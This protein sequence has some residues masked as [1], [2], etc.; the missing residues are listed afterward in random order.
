MASPGIQAL[1]SF[2][3]APP[4]Q[5]A[6]S[7]LR[8]GLLELAYPRTGNVKDMVAE[9]LAVRSEPAHHSDPGVCSSIQHRSSALMLVLVLNDPPAKPS[10]R[11]ASTHTMNPDARLLTLISPVPVQRQGRA[12]A[13]WE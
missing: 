13:E 4:E 2:A 1:R 11:M 6:H 9:V 5:T 7:A 3:R 8:D 12:P 10:L